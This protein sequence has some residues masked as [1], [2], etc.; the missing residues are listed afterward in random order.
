MTDTHNRPCA[1]SDPC[2]AALDVWD[3]A[4]GRYVPAFPEELQP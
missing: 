4:L 3:A 2:A 1:V